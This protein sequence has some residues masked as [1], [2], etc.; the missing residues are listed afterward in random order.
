MAAEGGGAGKKRKKRSANIVSLHGVSREPV[1]TEWDDAQRRIGNLPPLESSAGE[2][3]HMS[4]LQTAAELPMEKKPSVDAAASKE[5]GEEDGVAR[6]QAEADE[7]AQH[8]DQEELNRLRMQRLDELK[9]NRQAEVRFGAVAPL[10]HADYKREVCEAGN[11]VGVVVFLSKAKG[12]YL[13]SYMLVILE[14]LAR[15]FGPIFSF[16][17]GSQYTVVLSSP[18]VVHQALLQNGDET[19]G[20]NVVQSMDIITG[21]MGIALQPDMQRWKKFQALWC[22]LLAR[23]RMDQHMTKQTWLSWPLRWVRSTT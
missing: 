5:N 8:Q 6:L 16:W 19:A 7:D 2:E 15:K 11:G 10:T 20:R 9:G 13:S 12:H 1:T 18:D 17:F 23:S 3:E 22:Y 14:K 21:G 4:A